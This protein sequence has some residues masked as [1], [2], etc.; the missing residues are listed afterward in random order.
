MKMLEYTSLQQIRINQ[1]IK[2]PTLRVI[3]EAN[4]NIGVITKEEALKIAFETGADLI[5]ISPNANPPVAKIMDHG[6]FLY[7]QNKKRK[8]S[9]TS[10]KT[11]TKSIQIKVGTGDHDLSL[12]AK[13]ISEWLSEGHRI[14]IELFLIGRLKALEQNFLKERIG[15]LLNLVTIDYKTAEDFKR[16]PK[17]L[18]I[19]IEK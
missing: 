5:E 3:N 4:E 16:S 2:A 11:E 9:A 15:R 1:Q 19:V 13:K 8:K 17:G 18:T 12:K 10:H 14:K 7:E 6:K